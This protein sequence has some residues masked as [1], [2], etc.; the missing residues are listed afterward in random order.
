MTDKEKI[1]KYLDYKGISKNKFYLKTG[2]SVGFLDSGSSLGVDKL[3]II[4][5]NYH[6]LNPMWIL[7]DKGEMI[8][9]SYNT[10]TEKITEVSE[11][12]PEEYSKEPG[13]PLLPIEAFGGDG[14]NTVLG[15]ETSKIQERYVI[16]L[17]EGLKID[18]MI[19]V[20]GSSMYP[21]YNSGDVVACRIIKDLLYVQWNKTYVIDTFTQGTLLKRLKKS[22][23]DDHVVCK[24][25]NKDY[26]EFEL[27][28]TDIRNIAMVVGVIRLE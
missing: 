27:P 23:I 7:S 4:T 15:I 20:R 2:L 10:S 28:K 16:P 3:R 21:K 8:L 1:I 24:S 9:K 12:E 14:D 18:F 5:D 17:F 6:D 19:A 25:D 11:P 13:Y 22:I 26:E